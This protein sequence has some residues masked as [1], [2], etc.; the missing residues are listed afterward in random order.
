M[1]V[2]IRDSRKK[3]KGLIRASLALTRVT[4]ESMCMKVLLVILMSMLN[5]VVLSAFAE[6]PSGK[7]INEGTPVSTTQGPTIG[8]V[9]TDRDMV[10][11]AT[12][13]KAG[14]SVECPDRALSKIVG[15]FFHKKNKT[16]VPDYCEYHFFEQSVFEE[17]LGD[18]YVRAEDNELTSQV[19]YRVEYIR[20][21]GEVFA[22][23]RL[24]FTSGL[25]TPSV[26]QHDKR[27]G[28]YRFAAPFGGE[29]GAAEWQVKYQKTKNDKRKS[30]NVHVDKMDVNDAGF[31][32]EVTN[33]WDDLSAG[34]TVKFSFLSIVHGKPIQMS[35]KKIKP[36]NCVLPNE[37]SKVD[38]YVCIKVS[39]SNYL[40][41]LI[42]PALWL[43]FEKV[44]GELSVFK[45][46]TNLRSDKGENQVGSIYYRYM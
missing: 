15:A 38:D 5:S 1:W 44:S 42:A 41:S 33:S 8:E 26:E 29:D 18:N 3:Y 39:I 9:V 40:I 6:D 24:D 22:E 23:K 35:A 45:G 28:E 13:G 2:N 34:E 21:S 43:T 30:W 20:M 31:V 11:E 19:N 37:H 14:K 16:N 10:D 7:P 32:R 36:E 12:K 25:K 46:I 27:S 17:V 4:K